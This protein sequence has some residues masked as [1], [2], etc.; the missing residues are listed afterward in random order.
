M[1]K[2]YNSDGAEASL[3]PDPN[4]EIAAEVAGRVDETSVILS[5]FP[6]GIDRQQVTELLGVEPTKAWD[7][8]ERH[9]I[10]L[11]GK[12]RIVDWG[13]WYLDGD[14]YSNAKSVDKKIEDLLAK[15]TKDL[16]T[17]RTLANNSEVFISIKA[18]LKNWNREL[19][20]LPHTLK[21]LSDRKI[22][23]NIDVYCWEDDEPLEPKS[24]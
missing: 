24:G 17:W 3:T 19:N 6:K 18:H 10:G 12:T 8:G 11:H 9:A 4:A 7:P 23:L 21:L 14:D 22:A 1:L 16:K 20:L 13:K 2:I 5:V 15:C